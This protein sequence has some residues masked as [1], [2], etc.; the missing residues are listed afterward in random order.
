MAI[1]FVSPKKKQRIFFI[2]GALIFVLVLAG[3][4]VLILLP[5]FADKSQ[6]VSVQEASFDASAIAINVGII[7][8]NKVMNLKPLDFQE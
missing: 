8:S 3:L 1:V 5:E 6:Q 2:A 7:D 4:S